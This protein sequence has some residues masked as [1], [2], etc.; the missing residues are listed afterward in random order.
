MNRV[1]LL[2]T[3]NRFCLPTQR[4]TTHKQT[5]QEMDIDY[6]M[7]LRRS[8]IPAGWNC[9][10]RCGSHWGRRGAWSA[11][12]LPPRHSDCCWES[13]AKHFRLS[14]NSFHAGILLRHPKQQT[15]NRPTKQNNISTWITSV[16]SQPVPAHRCR[17][18]LHHPTAISFTAIPR[19]TRML[20]ARLSSNKTTGN[21]SLCVRNTATSIIE[22]RNNWKATSNGSILREIH[23]QK[24]MAAT[25]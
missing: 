6:L 1:W 3:A 13:A 10:S 5:N 24:M 7:E 2:V 8:R 16:K 22:R 15:A 17:L 23:F 21:E 18:P 19:P 12:S 11:A 9:S 14:R 20:N 4:S 25:R